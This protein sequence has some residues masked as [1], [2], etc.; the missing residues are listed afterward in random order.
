MLVK[1]TRINVLFMLLQN[2][3]WKRLL[4]ILSSSISRVSVVVR[5]SVLYNILLGEMVFC[6]QTVQGN[7][8]LKQNAF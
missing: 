1:I 6:F 8:F 5:F 4:L 2:T 7:Q 3:N